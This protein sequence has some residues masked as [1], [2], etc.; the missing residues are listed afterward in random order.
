MTHGHQAI[1]Q[2]QSPVDEGS[3][4]SQPPN[5]EEEEEEEEQEAVDL[6]HLNNIKSPNC[7]NMNPLPQSR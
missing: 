2:H 5:S 3:N 7:L 4:S 6:D 1:F